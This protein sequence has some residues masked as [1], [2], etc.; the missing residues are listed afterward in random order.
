MLSPSRVVSER[1]RPSVWPPGPTKG[2]A[3]QVP[4]LDR[5]VRVAARAPPLARAGRMPGRQRLRRDPDCE[6]TPLLQRPVVLW[7]VADLV[8][9]PGDLVPARFIGLSRASVIRRTREWPY[10]L[11]RG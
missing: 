3:Q 5:H 2:Q 9:R 1:S 11:H 8:A 6:A 7:P 10:T 4:G